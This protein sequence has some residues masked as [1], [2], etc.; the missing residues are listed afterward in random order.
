MTYG[1]LRADCLYAGISSGPNARY[2]VW[3]SLYLYL[4]SQSSV[5]NWTAITTHPLMYDGSQWEH[6]ESV[7]VR[8]R[9][10]STRYIQ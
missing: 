10:V 2:R 8:C 5:T 1:H 4:V 3:E 7:L 9:C 6:D